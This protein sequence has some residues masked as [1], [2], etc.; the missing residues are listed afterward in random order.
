MLICHHFSMGLRNDPCTVSPYNIRTCQ[1]WCITFV[2]IVKVS[3]AGI[4]PL[5]PKSYL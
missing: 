4:N 1:N 2:T 3:K 5:M